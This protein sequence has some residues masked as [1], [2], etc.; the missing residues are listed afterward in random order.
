MRL[1]IKKIEGLR[2]GALRRKPPPYSPELETDLVNWTDDSNWVRL[3]G[4][5]FWET[6]TPDKVD[7]FFTQLYNKAKAR[8]ATLV[9]GTLTT[10]PT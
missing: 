3:L 10:T 7:A 1:N 8:I 4:I 5:P 9:A 6:E 2:C